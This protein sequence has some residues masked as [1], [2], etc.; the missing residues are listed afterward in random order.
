MTKALPILTL[1]LLWGAVGAQTKSERELLSL[2]VRYDAAIVANDVAALD[3]IFADDF[4][5][6]SPEGELRTKAQQ[7]EMVRAGLLKLELGKSNDVSVRVYGNA[8]VM[9]G[10]FIAK[11]KFRTEPLDIRERYTATWVRQKGR[12]RLAAEQGVFIRPRP[13]DSPEEVARSR[14]LDFSDAVVRASNSG[15]ADKEVGDLTAIYTNDAILFPPKGEPVKGSEAIRAYW[16]RPSTNRIL[17][18]SVKTERAEM[19]GDL[20]VEHGYFTLSH[21]SGSN[22]AESGSAKFIS[23]WKKGSDGIWRKHLDSWW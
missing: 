13:S 22:R 11:G 1:V 14:G 16:T 23:V 6:T 2:N 7:L 4:V 10:L 20:L 21:Q 8:A 9:T 3:G 15:W 19:S 17:G 12:W 5:Y 18:H